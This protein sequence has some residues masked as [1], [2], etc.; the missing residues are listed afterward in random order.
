MSE[1]ISSPIVTSPP[2]KKNQVPKLAWKTYEKD[3]IAKAIGAE[4]AFSAK[5]KGINEPI[6][7]VLNQH[8]Q[9]L[10]ASTRRLI[11][12]VPSEVYLPS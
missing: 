9:L 2:E 6:K 12:E 4:T 3:C 5:F 1:E 11:A 7:L 10:D 8:G